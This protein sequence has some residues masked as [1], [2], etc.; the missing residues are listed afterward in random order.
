MNEASFVLSILGLI[1][2]IAGVYFSFKAFGAAVK[3]GEVVKLQEIGSEITEMVHKCNIDPAITFSQTSS[4]L[5]EIAGGAARLSSRSRI[6]P[7][8]EP[9]FQTLIANVEEARTALNNL[10]PAQNS[11]LS[12]APTNIYLQL[13]P[14]FSRIQLSLHTLKGVVEVLLIKGK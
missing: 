14:Y 9:M 8:L 3:A 10:N 6:A 13:D 5:N 11:A 1:A 4:L 7:S 2:S 12:A